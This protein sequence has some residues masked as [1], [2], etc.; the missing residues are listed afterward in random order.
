[1]LQ[2]DAREPAEQRAIA[3]ARGFVLVSSLPLGG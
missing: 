2:G 3:R 1:M